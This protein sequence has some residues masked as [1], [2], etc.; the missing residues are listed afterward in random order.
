MISQNDV[1]AQ[2]SVANQSGLDSK[3][4]PDLKVRTALDRAAADAGKFNRQPVVE[5]AIRDT[6]GQTYVDLGCSRSQDAICAGARFVPPGIG[7]GG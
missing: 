2:A 1:L 3:T 5:A 4:D 7:G 6:I